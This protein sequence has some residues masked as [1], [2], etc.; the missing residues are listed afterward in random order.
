MSLSFEPLTTMAIRAVDEINAKAKPMYSIAGHLSRA[1]LNATRNVYD[2]SPSRHMTQSDYSAA[3]DA[4]LGA[5]DWIAR[6]AN[7]LHAKSNAVTWME[8]LPAIRHW[9]S[10]AG[11]NRSECAE[12]RE[13]AMK[14]L[15]RAENNPDGG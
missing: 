3:A 11:G 1:L 4:A 13:R 10:L 7:A 5:A 9:C 12:I 14:T 6:D 2:V 8:M 15:A